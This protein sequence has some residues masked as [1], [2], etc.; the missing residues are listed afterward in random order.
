MA[1]ERRALLAHWLAR[2]LG[3]DVGPLVPASADASFR[4][5]WRFAYRGRTLI[6]VDAPPEHEDS[7]RFVRLARAFR[8]AGLNAP[9]VLAED[10]ARGFL[11]VSDLGTRT[12]L[13][14]LITFQASA[15]ASVPVPVP[16]Q[17]SAPALA[18][19]VTQ[20]PASASAQASAQ[21]SVQA[22]VQAQ[23]QDPA[24]AWDQAD[25]L[26]G[27]A[28]AALV[29][30]QLGL[31][32]AGLPVYDAAFL[33]REL[34]LFGDWLLARRLRIEL[35][36]R[37]AQELETLFDRL[38]EN[39]LEQPRVAV[40][41]DF[42]SRNLMLTTAANPGVLDLQDAV[43]GP[44]TY[45]LV[46]LLKD[47]YIAWPRARVLGWLDDYAAQAQSAGLL[48]ATDRPKLR[49]W[50]DLMGAQRHLKAA[51]IF[52]RLAVRDGKHGYLADL[53][54]TLGYLQ[55]LGPLYPEL[56]P[57]ATLIAQRLVPRLSTR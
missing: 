46:S 20:S 26:Y 57:L 31:S 35:S 23:A 13:S 16:A 53:P 48:K 52:A 55:E 49:R 36:E 27:D 22:S 44:L 51:G 39:A 19:L 1:D 9:E 15:S 28:I 4:R 32:T 29:K 41:R 3:E 56:Q 25:I 10:L 8:H 40:H 43:S 12:Y 17:P 30:L 34:D 5:Y 47:C 7:R 2:E 37:E 24:L 18:H 14:V 50:F 6:A 33:R 54:R 45:D 21:A 11:I 42:H 38:I